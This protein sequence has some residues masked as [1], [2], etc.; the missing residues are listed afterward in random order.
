MQDLYATGREAFDDGK[1]QRAEQKFD[2]L[3]QKNGPRTDAALYWKAYAENQ[4]GKRDTALASIA[5]LKTRFPQSRWK[6]DGEA[7]EMEVRQS[8]GHPVNPES[9]SDEE[10]KTLA[11]Q[12]VMNSD[13][14]R[15]IQII[16][17]R[18]DG[19]ASPKD[20]SKML[21]VLAQ[22]GSSKA[23]ELLAKI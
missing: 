6:K 15:G 21:F 12:G 22:N 9:Q 16:E 5:S 10:L 20:K 7:L 8:S 4:S 19:T 1:Y 14:E 3:A 13:P 23:Q 2:E 18:L 11:L 17:K